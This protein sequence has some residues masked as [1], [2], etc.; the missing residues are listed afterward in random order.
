MFRSLSSWFGLEQPA[1][2]G[3]Q[4]QG[5]GQPR[6]HAPP[7]QR[8]EAVAESVEGEPQLAGN[9]ELLHQAKGL[10]S[11]SPLGPQGFGELPHPSCRPWVWTINDRECGVG[12]G[13][14]LC[15]SVD[16]HRT[17]EVGEDLGKTEASSS[18]QTLCLKSLVASD[19]S[20]FAE[21]VNTESRGAIKQWGPT[22][23][24]LTGNLFY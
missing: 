1:A 19:M 17:G 12:R 16:P 9:Q 14:C 6:G 4:S 18:S 21:C 13:R 3:R 23:L 2:G 7:D 8:S 10:G 22:S 11:E 20:L 24:C 5:D 15:R